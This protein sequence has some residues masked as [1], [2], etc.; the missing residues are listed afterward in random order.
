MKGLKAV[1]RA[2]HNIV[3]KDKT[4]WVQ[5]YYSIKEDKVFTK[6]GEGRYYLTNLLNVN[7]EKDVEEAVHVCLNM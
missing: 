3:Q 2:T 5:L 6:P 7:T 1:A 4:T